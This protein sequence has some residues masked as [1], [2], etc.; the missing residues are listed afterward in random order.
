[1]SR[2]RLIELLLVFGFFLAL[3]V[4]W[5]GVLPLW[6]GPDEPAHFAYVQ[7]MATHEGPP[8]ERVVAPGR[9]PWIFS[10]S[11]AESVA[12]AVT[13]RNRVLAHPAAWL[14]V[15]PGE[16]LRAFQAVGAASGAPG[17]DRAGSQNYVGIYPPLYYAVIGRV[18][19]GLHVRNVFDQAFGAR[20]ASAGLL[21]I[22]GVLMDLV[23]GLVLRRAR[24]RAALTAAVGLLFP[25]LGMLGGVVTNDL[26]ADAASLAVFYLAAGA[27]A[28]RVRAASAVWF[29]VVAGLVIWTK[30]EAYVGLAVSVPFVLRR[31]WQPG[32]VRGA[33][34]WTAVAA[35][36]GLL[37]GGPWLLWA[38][39]AYHGLVPPL[40]YQGVGSEPRSVAWVLSQQLFNGAFLQ[41][42][43]VTQTVFGVNFPWW[44]PWPHHQA[45]FTIIGWILVAWLVAGMAAARRVSGFWLAVVWLA[46]GAGVMA[47]LQVQ[48][49]LATGNSFLQGRY[50]FFL[51]GPFLWLAA[52]AVQRVA[53]VAVPLVLLGAA[54]LSGAVVN[55]TLARYYH[56]NIGMYLTG[57]VVAFG[58]PRA[59]ALGPVALGVVGLGALALAISALT[60]R[61]GAAHDLEPT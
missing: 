3:G 34:R 19:A 28:G 25:T 11:P 58:P 26:M 48:Y 7:Y 38:W 60:L 24:L 61:R 40:T 22:T 20:L 9:A 1:M 54:V 29:G 35:G 53:R 31:V 8:S 4:S 44:L 17:G 50:F 41:N 36:F 47:A 45:V 13:Q 49:T 57:R 23:V 33:L 46:A 52:H 15:T 55:A 2:R 6:Q 16:A 18:E 51:L 30:E 12:I 56:A 32:T 59:L 39:H 14:S 21:G 42:V 37:V 27:M 5:M 43:L 10:P